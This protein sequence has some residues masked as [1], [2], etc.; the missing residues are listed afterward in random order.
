M[1]IRQDNNLFNKVPVAIITGEGSQDNVKRAYTYPI[2]DMLQKPFNEVNVKNIV[3][4][5]LMVKSMNDEASR[6]ELDGEHSRA[7]M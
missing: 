6:G 2:I 4:K 3:D 7:R 1:S 5:L